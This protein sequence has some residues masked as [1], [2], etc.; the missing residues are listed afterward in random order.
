MISWGQ[1]CDDNYTIVLTKK[2]LKV[3][4]KEFINSNRRITGDGVW[5]IPIPQ[6]E[7][8]QK[9]YG[10]TAKNKIT[11]PTPTPNSLNII[12]RTDKRAS[13]LAAYHH[14]NKH[15]PQCT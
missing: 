8:I 4:K 7:A 15:L 12:L 3:I 5:D 10:P 1:L 11:Y 14:L 2:N 6:N 9:N 13:D